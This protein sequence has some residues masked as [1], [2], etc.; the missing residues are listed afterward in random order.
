M[1]PWQLAKLGE[2]LRG[3]PVPG[4][5]MGEREFVDWVFDHV[6]AEWVEGEVILMA[7]ANR[8]HETLDEWLGRLLGEYVERTDAGIL[9]R[10]MLLRFPRRRRLRVP[11]QMFV[12][13]AR[14]QRVRPTFVAGPPD[15]IVEFVSP[16]SRNR[17]RRDKYLEY[18][19]GGVREYWIID[20]MAQTL[21]AYTLKGRKYDEILPTED[22]VDSAVLPG[23]YLRAKWL[24]GKQRPKVAQVL[25]EFG[26]KG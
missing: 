4:V 10:N 15:L 11:D 24:F 9:I 16:D 22:R 26:I 18:E 25:K 23:F 20:P 2:R 7:P 19:A 17:D 3:S 6:D 8:D 1:D 13:K 12:S 5:R 14:A 21:D